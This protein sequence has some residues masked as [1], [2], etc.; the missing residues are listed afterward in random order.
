MIN[1]SIVKRLLHKVE[2]SGI[3]M[4]GL[5]FENGV[6]LQPNTELIITQHTEMSTILLSFLS[7]RN[8]SPLLKWETSFGKNVKTGDKEKISTTN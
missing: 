2:K 5:N 4:Y 8:S 7:N 6:Y 1:T 3:C